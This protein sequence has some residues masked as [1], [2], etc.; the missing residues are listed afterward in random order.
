MSQLC[1]ELSLCGDL[2][3]CHTGK[4]IESVGIG[5]VRG[6]LKFTARLLLLQHG[7]EKHTP[8]VLNILPQ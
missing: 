4:I 7:L 6:N 3:H 1:S 8:A 2:G 5:C